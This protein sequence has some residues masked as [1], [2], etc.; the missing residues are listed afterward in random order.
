MDA[1]NILTGIVTSWDIT[2]SLANGRVTLKDIIVRNVHTASPNDP[3]EAAS[4]KLAH[5][6]ISSLPVIDKENRVKGIITSEDISKL[7]G[8]GGNG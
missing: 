1:E 4:R 5:F 6:N 7:L 3:I 8:G 2:R